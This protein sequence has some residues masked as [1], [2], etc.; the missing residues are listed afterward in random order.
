MTKPSPPSRGPVGPYCRALQRGVLGDTISGTSREGKFLRRVEA[1]LTAHVGDAPSFPQV[2]LIR[3][4]SR[5]MLRLELL[6]AKMTDGS[7]TDHDWR[8]FG[9]L[10]NSVRLMLRELGIKSAPPSRRLSVPEY[11]AQ[12]DAE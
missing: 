11:L 6:D 4:V 1:E 10:S 8:V 12:R 5:A 7:A 9:G 2:L 3:R